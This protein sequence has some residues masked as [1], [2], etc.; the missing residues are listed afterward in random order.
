MNTGQNLYQHML[1]IG[2]L[3]RM[4]ELSHQ[5]IEAG[6]PLARLLQTHVCGVSQQGLVVGAHIDVHGEALGWCVT[7]CRRGIVLYCI[8]W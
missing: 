4:H 3:A 6:A 5:G 8:V 7:S 2:R 1:A